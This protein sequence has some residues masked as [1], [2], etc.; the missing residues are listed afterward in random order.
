MQPYKDIDGDSGVE[1]YEY[2]DDY[3]RIKFK[4]TGR[5]YE[6]TNATAGAATISTMKRL[7]DSGEGLQAFIN[8]HK[9]G[10]VR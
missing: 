5:I 9:P 1:A 6:Y 3:I 10:F 7:A 8:T 2:G 4:N